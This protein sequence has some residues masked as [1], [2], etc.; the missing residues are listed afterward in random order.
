MYLLQTLSVEP[1]TAVDVDG[2]PDVTDVVG[3][4]GS[5]VEQEERLSSRATFSC[6]QPLGKLVAGDGGRLLHHH[7]PLHRH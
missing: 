6:S 3:D 2:A 7:R 4:E 5:T 1:I